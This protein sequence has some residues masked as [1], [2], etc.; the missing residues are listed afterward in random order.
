MQPRH[1]ERRPSGRPAGG[2]RQQGHRRRQVA[3]EEGVEQPLRLERD[4]PRAGAEQRPGAVADVGADVEGEVA[5]ADEA[6]VEA[7][8]R[9]DLPRARPR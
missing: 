4:D 5:R 1:R 6:A 2:E 9:G 7:R 8:Q 3:A